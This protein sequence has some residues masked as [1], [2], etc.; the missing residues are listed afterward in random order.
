MGKI[1]VLIDD[2]VLDCLKLTRMCVILLKEYFN[3][4]IKINFL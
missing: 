3:E 1:L 4:K 2:K